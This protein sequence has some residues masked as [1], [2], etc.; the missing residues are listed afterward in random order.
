MQLN[1]GLK[2]QNGEKLSLYFFFIDHFCQN[3]ISFCKQNCMLR[4]Y[5]KP[6][7]SLKTHWITQ[8]LLNHSKPDRNWQ[9]LSVW[10]YW[11]Y[12]HFTTNF[13]RKKT[14]NPSLNTQFCIKGLLVVQ[15]F[16]FWAVWAARQYWKTFWANY[17]P[18]LRSIFPFT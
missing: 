2:T 10:M 11:G 16:H 4:N 14:C 13:M 9:Q 8:S 17:E 12:D 6:T 7:K 1:T 15:D 3:I 5:S 18:L